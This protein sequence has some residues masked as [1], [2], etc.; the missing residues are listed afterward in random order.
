MIFIA[1]KRTLMHNRASGQG[2]TETD[3]S[4]CRFMR[5]KEKE[6]RKRSSPH[7]QEIVM[8]KDCTDGNGRHA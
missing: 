6:K 7:A 2:E 5:M 3:L 8:M 1:A 4:R